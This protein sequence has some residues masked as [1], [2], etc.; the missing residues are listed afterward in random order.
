MTHRLYIRV[1]PGAENVEEREILRAKVY[2]E[3]ISLNPAKV[4]H[5]AFTI[6]REVIMLVEFFQSGMNPAHNPPVFYAF[7]RLPRTV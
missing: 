6:A 1:L 4:Y 5:A 2:N 3:R 7:V